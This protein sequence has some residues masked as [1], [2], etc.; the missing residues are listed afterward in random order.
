MDLKKLL[1]IRWMLTTLFVIAGVAFLIRLGFWQLDRL[2]QR[3]AYNASVN[4]QI[5]APVMN[6]NAHAGDTGLDN[7]QYRHVSVTGTYAFDQQLILRNT[8]NN[9]RPGMDLLTPLVIQGT[10]QSV[11][12]DRGWIPLA[13]ISRQQWKPYDENGTVTL[14]GILRK[15]QSE[16]ALGAIDPSVG[17]LDAINFVVLNRIRSQVNTPLLPVYIQQTGGGAAAQGL[18]ARTEPVFDLSEGP[19]EGYALQWFTF[20]AILAIGY[21][22]YVRKQLEINSRIVLPPLPAEHSVGPQGRSFARGEPQTETEAGNTKGGA[23]E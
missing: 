4:A 18:P 1:T 9:G 10:G 22:F 6:L 7:L 16:P 3:R 2:A 14:T 20:A 23:K 12:V 8:V 13:D 17:H 11:L 21:P 15:T 19:H 5:N